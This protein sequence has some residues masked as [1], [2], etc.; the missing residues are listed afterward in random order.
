MKGIELF[1]FF[2]VIQ[3]ILNIKRGLQTQTKKTKQKILD[4]VLFP[5]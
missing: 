5:F 4:T 2:F 1:C 3:T